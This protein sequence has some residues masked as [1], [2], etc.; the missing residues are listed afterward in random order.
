M[1]LRAVITADIVNS[2][3]LLPAGEKK[4]IHQ[5]GL[6]LNPFK[7]EFYRGDSFQVYLEAPEQA[8]GVALQCRSLAI[9]FG[10]E[11]GKKITDVRIG[12]GL[13]K[14]IS[15]V[16]KPGE[17]NGEAF[18]LSGRVFDELEKSGA[19]LAIAATNELANLGFRVISDYLNS[20][21]MGMTV[22]QAGVIFEML[23][24][25]SQQETA[26]KLKKSKS[27][28][29]QH[30]EAGRWN[31]MEKLIQQYQELVTRINT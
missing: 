31:E 17:G 3:K 23:Q 26:L 8:L 28:I 21:C 20:I 6:I 12:I 27:T 9:H 15:P 4:L 29:H 11:K 24:G 10:G 13:G 2:T 14:V 22:K 16:I 30:L 18:L 1:S 19:R 5:L 7:F 25:K